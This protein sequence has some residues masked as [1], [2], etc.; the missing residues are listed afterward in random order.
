[1]TRLCVISHAMVHEQNRE[2]WRRLALDYPVDVDLVVPA[3]WESTWFG[4]LT[5]WESEPSVQGRFAV[6]PLPTTNCR[7]WGRYRVR[8][9]GG[10]L[11]RR[12]PDVILAYGEEFSLVLH[13]VITLRHFCPPLAGLGF[14]TWNNLGIITGRRRWLKRLFWHRVCR[15]TTFAIAGN[16]AGATLMRDAG[17]QR[18][19]TVQ[20]EIGIDE[21]VYR[22]DPTAGA[23]MRRELG[24]E[25]FVVGFAGRITASKGVL[26]LFAALEQMALPREW[27]LLMVG[28]GDLR[29]VLE[30]RARQHGW[31]AVFTGQLEPSA[32]PDRL[33][34]MDCLVL[35]SRTCPD[36]KEQFGLVLAQAMACGIPV[37]GSDSGAIPEVIGDVGIVFTEGDIAALADAMRLLWANSDRCRDHAARGAK[38]AV[39][40]YGASALAAQTVSILENLKASH[41]TIYCGP[42]R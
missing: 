31:R 41:K 25:G 29:S 28:D 34:A 22:P 5:V 27:S 3:R 12:R 6:F 2:R 8:G 15:G 42:N 30:D 11:R 9:L 13:Q 20:T 24:L 1:M 17:Y 38:R 40:H 7:D 18:P 4:N 23:A 14:F 35:P 37:I 36:W 21:T 33:R 19:I 39:S 26:D 10:L 16:T 32:M